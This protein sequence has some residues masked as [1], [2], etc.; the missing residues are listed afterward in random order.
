[1]DRKVTIIGVDVP[2]SLGAAIE[3]ERT[4]SSRPVNRIA[5]V[6]SGAA[7]VLAAVPDR[8]PAGALHPV[9]IKGRKRQ[10][11]TRS[12]FRTVKKVGSWW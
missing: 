2:E 9:P 12:Q 8:D 3:R 10:M 6:V 7:A 5:P 11:R 4:A 1:L